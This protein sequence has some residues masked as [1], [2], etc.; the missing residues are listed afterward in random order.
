MHVEKPID[1]ICIAHHFG[2]EQPATIEFERLDKLSLLCL[3]VS[4]LFDGKAEF[5]FF[6][7]D[8]LHGL[9][10]IT[11][12][13]ACEKNG[14]GLYRRLYGTAQTVGINTAVKDIKKR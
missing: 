6:Q 4:D 12:L 7:I 8:G 14:M 10:L 1:M 3:K 2:M 5:L 9:S 13:N 11:Q